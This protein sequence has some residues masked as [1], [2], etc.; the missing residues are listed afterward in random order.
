VV[1]CV[2]VCVFALSLCA[3]APRSGR[4]VGRSLLG[5]ASVPRS[6]E[7]ARPS[8]SPS[9]CW[10]RLE[11]HTHTHTRTMIIHT[12]IYIH[13]HTLVLSPSLA[14]TFDLN[15]LCHVQLYYLKLV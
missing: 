15:T 6:S 11:T 1:V 9:D 5:V 4:G 14:L 12:S 2:C 10:T 13:T 3:V 7:T 8:G